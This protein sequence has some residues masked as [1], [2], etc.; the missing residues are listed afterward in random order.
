MNQTTFPESNYRLLDFG[1]GRKLEQFGDRIVDR[2]C[3]GAM[4]SKKGSSLWDQADLSYSLKEK[5]RWHY[6]HSKVPP[7]ATA[8]EN[9]FC[10]CDGIRM[11]LKPTP[12]GQVGVF[13]EHWGHWPWLLK[14]MSLEDAMLAKTPRVLSLFA[15]TGATTLA[16]ARAGC[17]VT[18]VDSSK[19]TVA[20]ARENCAFSDLGKVSIRWI[21]DDA[22]TFV[23]RELRRNAQYEAILL[24]PP[25]YGHGAKG[26]RWEIHRHLMPLLKDCWQLL[27]DQRRAVLLCG[28][29]SHIAVRDINEKL[30]QQYGAESISNCEITQANLVDLSGRKLDCGFAARYS[31]PE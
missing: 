4:S 24:D 20:W 26:A 13:P 10:V 25:T 7:V 15:Y 2:P 3:P 29:S 14:K 18:H 30:A 12:A 8:K 11:S 1:M 28:H 16:L 17:A 22:A 19:P 5:D 21:V 31:F 23:K 9:W 6:L 27:S